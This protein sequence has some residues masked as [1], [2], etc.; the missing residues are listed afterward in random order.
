MHNQSIFSISIKIKSSLLLSNLLF[1]L[2]LSGQPEISWQK[3]LGGSDDEIHLGFSCDFQN[4]SDGG[5]I[6]CGS[7][8][9]T[10][11]DVSGIH[12]SPDFPEEPASDAWVVKTDHQGNVEWQKCFGGTSRDAALSVQQTSDG[13]YIVSGYALSDDGDVVENEYDQN[14]NPTYHG[15]QDIWI[16][17]L[18]DLGNIEW[19]KCLGGQGDEFALKIIQTT[20]GGFI[21]AGNT[22]GSLYGEIIDVHGSWDIWIVKLSPIGN[23]EWQNCLGGTEWDMCSDISQASDG[24]FILSGRTSS[25][26][27]D[28]SGWH[29]G[30][31]NGGS[32]LLEDFW[33]VKLNIVGEIEWQKCLG[34]SRDDWAS[35]ITEATDGGYIVTGFTTSSDGD[36]SGYY[37]T[38]PFGIHDVWIV[39][40]DNEGNFIWQKCL[41][42]LGLDEAISIQHDL[43]GYILVGNTT[44]NDG[45][46]NGFIGGTDFWIVQTDLMGNILWQKV[47]GGTSSESAHR[48]LTTS[49]GYVVLGGTSSN[50]IDVSGN[51][52][53]IDIWMVKL[54]NVSSSI[55]GINESSISIFPTPANNTLTIE[56]SQSINDKRFGIFEISGKV[57][58]TGTINSC[59]MELN[60]E[61]LSKGVYTMKIEGEN[62]QS[63]KFIKE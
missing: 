53:G 37:G 33:V 40:L 51:N 22:Y 17:K 30:T 10:D 63:L 2:S 49:D 56:C 18:D 19:Q 60:I 31:A 39:K 14:G 9:S 21:I 34:G 47:I 16:L 36:V 20:D 5:F 55:S 35:S 1:A 62:T 46:V 59:R 38:P 12:I 13:G 42:G 54:N 52:G 44:S 41:G 58:M 61:Q 27:G 26:N 3:C 7:T 23:I 4:T 28:V 50:D 6:I 29:F 11:G 57:V 25:N 45:D 8:K 15:M 24:G 48:V 32:T 43:E